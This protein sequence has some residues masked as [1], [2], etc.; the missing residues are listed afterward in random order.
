MKHGTVRTVSLLVAL[1]TTSS[2]A[3]ADDV[4]TGRAAYGDWQNDAPGVMRKITVNDL[5]PPRNAVD[6]RTVRRSSPRPA[7]NSKTMPGFSVLRTFCYGHG[8]ARV[9]RVAQRQISSW[10]GADR[11]AK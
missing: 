5:T 9:I 2:W 10:R 7:P 8:E 3:L 1:L 11:K 4:R 6:R